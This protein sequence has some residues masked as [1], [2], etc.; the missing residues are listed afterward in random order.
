MAAAAV[1]RLIKT[2]ADG[3]KIVF[4][5]IGGALLDRLGR[6]T[7]AMSPDAL[8]LSPE[9]YALLA[10]QLGQLLDRMLATR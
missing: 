1:N 3:N 8:H 9:G 4:A 2:C 10:P 7:T 5:E 6:L